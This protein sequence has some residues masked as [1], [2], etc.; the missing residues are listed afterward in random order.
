[1]KRFAFRA[2][3][4][5]DLRRRQ[6]E[7]AQRELAAAEARRQAAE[8]R[9]DALRH[10]LTAT[11]DRGL[12]EESRAG[13]LTVRLWY[14]NWI[15]GQRLQIE[16]CRSVLDERERDATQAAE[17]AMIAYRRRRALERFHDRALAAWQH[18]ERH[19]EQKA[20][21]ELASTRHA[22]RRA[23]GIQ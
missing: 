16:R 14:R 4:A 13:D 20:I 1:M 15:A 10:E 5:L 2:A 19:E 6:E 23:G 21:D 17:R 8:Q 11:F 18:A 22:R 3:A 9:L 7:E 12:T